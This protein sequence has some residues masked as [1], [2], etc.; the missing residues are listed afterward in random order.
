[1]KEKTQAQLYF[2]EIMSDIYELLKPLGFKKNGLNFYRQ[3]DGFYHF[4]HIQKSA[5]NSQ[6]TI[7]F[8]MNIGV[9]MADN[10]TKKWSSIHDFAVRLRVGDLVDGADFWYNLDGEILDIFKRKQAF[11]QEKQFALTH[12]KDSVLLFF[13][14]INSKETIENF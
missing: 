12:L 4:I 6:N 7:N 10:P 2:D 14:Q 9:D 11:A 3:K 8:T 5:Y 1:M 13:G